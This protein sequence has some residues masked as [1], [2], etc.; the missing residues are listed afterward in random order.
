[1]GWT[2]YF[3]KAVDPTKISGGADLANFTVP[4]TG[5]EVERGF[6]LVRHQAKAES[7]LRELARGGSQILSVIAQVDFYGRDGSGR[8]IQATGYLNITFADFGNQ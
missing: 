8:A 3:E 5:D 2:G 6:L 1:M 7:P 4:I